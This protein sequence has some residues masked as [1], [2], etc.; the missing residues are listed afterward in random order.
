MKLDEI[1][2]EEGKIADVHGNEKFDYNKNG[3]KTNRREIIKLLLNKQVL[4]SGF[5]NTKDLVENLGLFIKKTKAGQDGL[6]DDIVK[7]SN[8]LLS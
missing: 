5:T 2:G 8:Q 3:R 4:A 7:I 1:E 6:Y